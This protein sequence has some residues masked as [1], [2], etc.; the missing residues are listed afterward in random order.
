MELTVDKDLQ[1]V[2]EFM[3]NEIPTGKLVRIAEAL[4][5]MARLLWERFPQEP[6]IEVRLVDT[7]F[8]NDLPQDA[9]VC[10][11]ASPCAGDDFGAARDIH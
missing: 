6:C 8:M 11:P 4:P 1:A 3:Q 2:I 9:S 7:R 5:K 10:A